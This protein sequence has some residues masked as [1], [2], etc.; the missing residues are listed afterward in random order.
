MPQPTYADGERIRCLKI[1]RTGDNV[2]FK[3]I[4]PSAEYLSAALCYRGIKPKPLSTALGSLRDLAYLIFLGLFSTTHTQQ[5]FPVLHTGYLLVI[6]LNLDYL[7]HHLSVRSFSPQQSYRT[8]LCYCLPMHTPRLALIKL[9]LCVFMCKCREK[10]LIFIFDSQCLS[11][12][13]GL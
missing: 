12:R 2:N 8:S 11:A 1:M 3:K 10:G 7:V 9:Q 5:I 6:F 13:P 4:T